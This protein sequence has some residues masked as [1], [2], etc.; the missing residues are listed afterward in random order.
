MIT[1]TSAVSGVRFNVRIIRTGDRYGMN[2]MLTVGEGASLRLEG[3]GPM[4]EFYDSRYPH[5]EF[6]QFVS[7]YGV[8]TILGGHTGLNLMGGV[9]DWQIDGAAMD[10]VR[11]WLLDETA[12]SY[13]IGV[14]VAVLV[15]PDG[16]V[17]FDFDLTE[18]YEIDDDD[19]VARYDED[20]LQA[21]ILTVSAAA[22]TLRNHHSI[23]TPTNA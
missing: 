9:A 16:S 10:V 17:K 3:P 6:G 18:V 7:R 11:R 12:R 1:V 20:T 8:S 4:V 5:T 21:D 22:A 23:T 19:A 2:N 14:P 15:R 13:S